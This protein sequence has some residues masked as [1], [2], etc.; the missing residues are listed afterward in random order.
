[1]YL[2][3]ISCG[4]YAVDQR[5]GD[6]WISGWCGI[7]V[8]YRRNSNTGFWSTRREDC[9]STEQNLPEYPFQEKGQTGGNES[10]QRRPFPSWKTDRLPDLRVLP[11]HWSQ[12]FCRELCRS[13]LQSLF[14][15]TIFRS[16]IRNWMKFYCRWHKSH[17]MSSWK[18]CVNQE[19]ESLRNS[20]PY[21]NKAEPDYHRLRTMVKSSIE[22]NLRMQNFED[23]NGN[24]ET[25]AVVTNPKVKQR[26]QRSL[27]YCWQWKANGQCSK[28]NSCSFRHDQDK[29]AKSKQPN[30][31]PR[32]S[33]QQNVKNA[34]GNKSPGDR[35]PSG[36]MAR[37]PCKD[38]L[39]GTC[40]KSFLW[41][42]ASSGVLVLQDRKWMQIWGY[43][44][45]RTPASLTNSLARSLKR[46]VTKLQWL[47]WRIH[48]GCEAAEVFID[49]AEE[50]K[51]TEANPMCSIH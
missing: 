39:K 13:I 3:T 2:F 35:S 19:Y 38:Y 31:S 4:S 23:R 7:F 1:M 32:S 25:S 24:F 40:T 44:L 49:M 16:S 5:S 45:P 33:T 11:G 41:K 37:L 9:F 27:G 10:S 6:G 17:L 14:E 48:E 42:M 12:R 15:M 46:M 50:L 47:Y 21:W 51:H 28:G 29:R 18:I 34:S 30:P 26:E 8:F 20:R 43:V 22:Q 36:K